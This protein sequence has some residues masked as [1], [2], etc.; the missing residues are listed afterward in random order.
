MLLGSLI[1]LE[2]L[3]SFLLPERRA[4][5]QGEPEPKP[6]THTTQ[7]PTPA[8]LRRTSSHSATKLMLL[9]SRIA[10]RDTHILLVEHSDAEISV[11]LEQAR[12]Q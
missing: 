9:I 8:A 1:A 3:L 2:S 11:N 12:F 6:Q 10:A 4:S 5:L 7:T